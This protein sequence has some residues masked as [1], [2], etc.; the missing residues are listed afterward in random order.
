M[1]LL[2]KLLFFTGDLVKD[3]I[4]HFRGEELEAKLANAKLF[5]QF[6]GPAR[7]VIKGMTELA[8]A[9]PQKPSNP[10]QCFTAE[11]LKEQFV[12]HQQQQMQ[13]RMGGGGG[14]RQQMVPGFM[15]ERYMQDAPYLKQLKDV[16]L[17]GWQPP[18]AKVAVGDDETN[19]KAVASDSDELDFSDLK[20][21]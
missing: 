7:H 12:L 11:Q 20:S 18:S 19:S 14:G 2:V 17:R 13:A 6:Y 3:T 21:S 5:F 8:I 4:G 16:V 10:P 15:Q 9:D 1:D